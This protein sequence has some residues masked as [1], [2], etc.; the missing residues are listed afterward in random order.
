MTENIQLENELLLSHCFYEHNST[1]ESLEH[2]RIKHKLRKIN[3]R[4]ES[5]D[6]TIDSLVSDLGDSLFSD[7]IPNSLNPLN[8]PLKPAILSPPNGRL[9]KKVTFQRYKRI[10]LWEYLGR[11]AGC[12]S[13]MKPKVTAISNSNEVLFLFGI[14]DS[15]I[16]QNLSI[17]SIRIDGIT[18]SLDFKL[19][20][21]GYITSIEIV[22]KGDF[23]FFGKYIIN[24]P[25]GKTLE[26]PFMEEIKK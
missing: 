17:D 26:I 4:L 6:Y 18:T 23:E 21:N 13:L 16:T 3:G 10:I 11:T 5:L 12:A 8:F 9:M 20:T 22:E 14:L 1:E 25:N 19:V 15:N 7:Y 2:T 24:E